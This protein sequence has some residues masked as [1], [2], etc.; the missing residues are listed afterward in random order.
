MK[1]IILEI[2]AVMALFSAMMI[3][4]ARPNGFRYASGAT[5]GTVYHIK[6]LSD[7]DLTDS[8]VAVMRQVDMSL[9]P[10]QEGSLV[11]RLNAG[12]RVKA[13]AML[14][15]VFRLSQRVCSISGGAFD[16]TVAPLVNLWGF[17]YKA[18]ETDVPDK[19][20][21]DSA[22]VTVGILD[23]GISPDGIICGKHPDTEYNFSAI[24]KG[25]GV[26][27]IAAMLHRNG[28]EDYMVE[29]GGEIALRGDGPSGDGW[30]IQVD[31]PVNES[32]GEA[33][34]H[35]ELTTLHLTDVCLATSG[36]YRNRRLTSKGEIWHTISPVTG[37][38]VIT[39]VLSSTILAPT[40]AFADAIA[41]ASM[42]MPLDEAL[43]MIQTQ[44]SVR[45]LLVVC[46][47]DS[48]RVVEVPAVVDAI[49]DSATGK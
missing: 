24:A 47:G 20:K 39:D 22:L 35:Q 11:S 17:G 27:M 16:P 8:I 48:L 5:W 38:P 15:D 34:L 41:T 4:C 6:Y 13:D 26:D 31:A 23:C 42:A 29:V 43:V 21:I 12:E 9:S 49:S 32:S 30:V 37:M 33:P 19:S 45:G 2:S 25:Y 10:F 14:A 46:D 36:N 18:R 7:M 44:M 1:R 3:A 40:T 28:C